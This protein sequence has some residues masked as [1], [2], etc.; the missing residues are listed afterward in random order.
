M[1]DTGVYQADQPTDG[2][3]RPPLLWRLGRDAKV[4]IP[5]G[6]DCPVTEA[7]TRSSS[8]TSTPL[9]DQ[10]SGCRGAAT[11]CATPLSL[12]KC[13]FRT[14]H[15]LVATTV[16]YTRGEG[17]GGGSEAKTKSRCTE[18]RPRILGP[19]DTFHFFPE[20]KIS[21][22]GGWVRGSSGGAHTAILPP[23]PP[24]PR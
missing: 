2:R 18:N 7:L 23:P 22:V 20:E 6:S 19:F 15:V 3:R 1:L 11:F 8:C 21:D 13:V 16:P 17:G 5:G 9:S 10:R 4:P 14:D 24:P 12:G